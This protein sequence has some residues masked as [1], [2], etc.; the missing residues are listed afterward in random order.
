[1]ISELA[2]LTWW[3]R[4]SGD[5]D[6]DGAD[7]VP[8]LEAVVEYF[9]GVEQGNMAS[10]AL[11]AKAGFEQVRDTPDEEGF[12]YLAMRPDGSQPRR[13]WVVPS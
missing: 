12:S 3:P 9:A 11:L 4:R 2:W 1:M 10:A 7:L 8:G 6:A 5:G 13:P